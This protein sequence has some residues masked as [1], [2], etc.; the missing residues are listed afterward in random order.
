MTIQLEQEQQ[1]I[2]SKFV[3]AFRNSP[4]TSAEHL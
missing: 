3:E 2:L 4:V 1:E